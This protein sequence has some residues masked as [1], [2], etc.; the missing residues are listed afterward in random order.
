M[1]GFDFSKNWYL[2]KI[3]ARIFG[4][5]ETV[6]M[7]VLSNQVR[8]YVH[9]CQMN[10]GTMLPDWNMDM[11]HRVMVVYLYERSTAGTSA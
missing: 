8:W 2:S 4:G 1:Q 11:E 3:F 6:S 9:H 10:A 5:G 7:Y